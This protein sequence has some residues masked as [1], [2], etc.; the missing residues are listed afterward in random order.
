MSKVI[1]NHEFGRL[2][3]RFNPRVPHRS[4]LRFVRAGL[5][6]P[7][8]SVDYT[9]SMPDD[10]SVMYN[11]F[12]GDCT[13][14]AYFHARQ[15]W[16][17]NAWGAEDTEPDSNVELMYEEA[18]GYNPDVP[19]P[20]PGGDEQSVLQYLLNTGAPV[21]ANG[22]QRDKILA[23]VE[24]DPKNISDMK[25]TIYECGVAYI[26]F[27]VPENVSYDNPV[28]DYDPQAPMTDDGHAVILAGYD[29]SGAVAISWGKRY[30]LTW[31][32]ICNIVDEA[33]AIADRA[34]IEATG[35]TP[36]GLS[37]AQLE[38]Q[39]QALRSG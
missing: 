38:E 19:G 39:M 13:C 10:F 12:L 2:A 24:V 7:P 34:W 3:R 30:K 31:A 6:L 15:I 17:F 28:W 36:A 21:G 25:N 1:R 11:D 5:S 14:A 26:G 29:E 37:L 16:T 23:Y 18:C 35:T 22:K 8:E 32:F 27:P 4:A 20:G 9:S 33:Y